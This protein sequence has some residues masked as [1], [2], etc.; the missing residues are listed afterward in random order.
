MDKDHQVSCIKSLVFNTRTYLPKYQIDSEQLPE[1]ALL[2]PSSNMAP[3]V[4]TP[5]VKTQTTMKVRQ[6][7]PF[8]KEG[9]EGQH[10]FTHTKM[11]FR[12][13]DDKYY[14]ATTQEIIYDDQ[15]VDTDGLELTP[16]PAEHIWPLVDPKFTR[17]PSA[18]L[19]NGNI[20]RP[21]LLQYEDSPD[22][23]EDSIPSAALQ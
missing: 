6:T 21:N 11:I 7:T 22:Y 18:R 2:V 16:I 14:P 23:P 17:V 19:L 13:G 4:K 3:P 5:A 20:K 9:E 8:F 15:V 12:T 10:I 1:S